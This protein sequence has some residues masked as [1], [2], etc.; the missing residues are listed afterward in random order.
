M[1]KEITKSIIL[2]QIQDKLGLREFDAAKFLFDE[3]VVPVYNIEAHLGDWDVLEEVKTISSAT[4]FT[5]FS[6]PMDERWLLRAYTVIFGA[7]GAHKGTGLFMTYRPYP[8][9]ESMY[10]DMT[11]G[12]EVSY[13]VTL[14]AI[15]VLNPKTQLKYLIDTYVCNQALT[16][17]IDVLKEK[18]R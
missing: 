9:I 18:I 2:Q 14:P 1:T 15:V 7:T 6:V 4:A 3:T 8:N 13:L 12:Q 11:K 10:L 17:N 16:I 5:F